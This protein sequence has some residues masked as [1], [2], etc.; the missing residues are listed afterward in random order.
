VLLQ[1]DRPSTAVRVVDKTREIMRVASL[2]MA[3]RL[4]AIAINN[5]WGFTTTLISVSVLIRMTW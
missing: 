4:F 1:Y 2:E 5:V 3:Q